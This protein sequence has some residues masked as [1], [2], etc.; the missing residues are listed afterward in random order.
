M[1]KVDRKQQ[2]KSE[3]FELASV[4]KLKSKKY[5]DFEKFKKLNNKSKQIMNQNRC[6][7]F[8]KTQFLEK[9]T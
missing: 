9:N 6:K 4:L 2:K 5:H 3:K 8:P 7:R 1:Q